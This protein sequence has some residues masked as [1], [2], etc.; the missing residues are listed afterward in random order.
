MSFLGFGR[1]SQ[2]KKEMISRLQAEKEVLESSEE[3]SKKKILK[4][5]NEAKDLRRSLQQLEFEKRELEHKLDKE[6]PY[7]KIY[8]ERRDLLQDAGVKDSKIYELEGE[9]NELRETVENLKSKRKGLCEN[10]ENLKSDLK[11]IQDKNDKL[12]S[13]VD[14]LR[15]QVED[16]TKGKEEL[17]LQM[18]EVE[19]DKEEYENEIIQLKEDFD[20]IRMEKEAWDHNNQTKEEK[21]VADKA[22]STDAI[23]YIEETRLEVLE[24]KRKADDLQLASEALKAENESLFRANESKAKEVNEI[25]KE[26]TEIKQ[27]LTREQLKYSKLQQEWEDDRRGTEFVLVSKSAKSRQN[28]SRAGALETTREENDSEDE[29]ILSLV[30]SAKAESEALREKERA[31]KKRIS[32]LQTDKADLFRSGSSIFMENKSLKA[33]YDG[34][35]GERDKLLKSEDALRR[36]TMEQAKEIADLKKTVDDMHFQNIAIKANDDNEHKRNAYVVV[37]GNEM[38]KTLEREKSALYRRVKYLEKENDEIE[39]RVNEL[40]KQSDTLIRYTQ[41]SDRRSNISTSNHD[42]RI[43]TGIVLDRYRNNFDYD[44]SPSQKEIDVYPNPRNPQHRL[45]SQDQ[46]RKPQSGYKDRRNRDLSEDVKPT[47]YRNYNRIRDRTFSHTS[48]DERRPLPSRTGSRDPYSDDQQPS[49]SRDTSRDP[50][51]QAFD[52]FRPRQP[53]HAPTV[54][55][56][57]SDTGESHGAHISLPRIND[58]LSP[59]PVSQSSKG[60]HSRRATPNLGRQ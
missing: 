2:S 31:Y 42:D 45:Y 32:E 11:L 12:N 29:H 37:M 23:S 5:D 4:L 8:N 35:L 43:N 28:R 51:T 21:L 7:E 59:R 6:E 18:K 44:Q 50:F 34:L 14:V 56:L 16:T 27:E 33:K 60:R 26:L 24:H 47:Q 52:P 58:R 15:R 57:G 17:E 46:G 19:K 22:V 1:K 10:V 38:I 13:D 20:K 39:S 36:K 30:E 53:R 48:R 49:P 3:E 41:T 9:R 25:K 55:T 54:E 40:Q